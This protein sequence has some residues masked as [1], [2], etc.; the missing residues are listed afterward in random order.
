M[1]TLSSEFEHGSLPVVVGAWDMTCSQ[2][3]PLVLTLRPEGLLYPSLAFPFISRTRHLLSHFDWWSNLKGPRD[4]SLL[5]A[6]VLIHHWVWELLLA[7]WLSGA[8]SGWLAGCWGCDCC[9]SM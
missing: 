3:P 1:I 7:R 4:S 9:C 6:H 5:I 2:H 8:M